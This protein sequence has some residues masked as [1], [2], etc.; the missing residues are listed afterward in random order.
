M[1]TR[2]GRIRVIFSKKICIASIIRIPSPS[3]NEEGAGEREKGGIRKF[4]A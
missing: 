1:K 4:K 2:L 3:E